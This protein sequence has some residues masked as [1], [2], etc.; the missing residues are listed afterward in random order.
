MLHYTQQRRSTARRPRDGFTSPTEEGTDSAV[1]VTFD[2]WHFARQLSVSQEDTTGF[3]TTCIYKEKE[4]EE[5]DWGS[6][7]LAAWGQNVRCYTRGKT[8]KLDALEQNLLV[9]AGISN[10]LFIVFN[11]FLI[12]HNSF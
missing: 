9:E 2:L 5:E 10:Y 6:T 1:N 11:V 7:E 4:D 8:F 12:F 3:Y